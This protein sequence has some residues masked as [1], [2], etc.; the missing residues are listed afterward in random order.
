MCG[1]GASDCLAILGRATPAPRFSWGKIKLKSFQFPLVLWGP[2]DEDTGVETNATTH[3]RDET[4]GK[5][6]FT[7]TWTKETYTLF[8]DL[9]SDETPLSYAWSKGIKVASQIKNWNIR[10]IKVTKAEDVK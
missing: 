10:D 4:M 9:P 6:T 8:F 1:A 7:N 5:A 3:T 2:I